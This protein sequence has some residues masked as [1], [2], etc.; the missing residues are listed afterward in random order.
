MC[1]GQLPWSAAGVELAL[2]SQTVRA[3]DNHLV[4]YCC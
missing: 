3:C 4:S 2:E 1:P